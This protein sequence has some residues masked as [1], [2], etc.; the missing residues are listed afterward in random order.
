MK[1][2]IFRNQILNFGEVHARRNDV[3]VGFIKSE[4]GPYYMY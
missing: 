1:V 4:R 2:S 3:N